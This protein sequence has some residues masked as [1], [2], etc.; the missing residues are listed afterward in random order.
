M[1]EEKTK[2]EFNITKRGKQ[3]LKDFG[4]KDIASKER[5]IKLKGYYFSD[6]EDNDTGIG[7]VA[8][9]VREAKKIGWQ[10]WGIAYG[11]DSEY[12]ELVCHLVKDANVDKLSIGVIENFKD[13]LKAGVFGYVEGER[14]EICNDEDTLYLFDGKCICLDCQDKLECEAE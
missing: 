1:T 7:I 14:C 10:Y 4:F 5:R 13:G 6:C 11:H 8:H 2:E 9:S 12:I 3:C